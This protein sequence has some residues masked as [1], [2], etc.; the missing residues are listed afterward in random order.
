MAYHKVYKAVQNVPVIFAAEQEFLLLW[1]KTK[2]AK[3]S[4]K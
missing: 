3:Y 4:V 2:C 1:L